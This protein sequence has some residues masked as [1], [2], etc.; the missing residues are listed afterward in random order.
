MRIEWGENFT[1]QHRTIKSTSD[2][3][4]VLVTYFSLKKYV[5]NEENFVKNTAKIEKVLTFW[6]TRN[7]SS[8]GD[9]TFFRP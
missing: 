8:E 3:I 4:N 5:K 9:V 2:S 7:L 1:M 6:R